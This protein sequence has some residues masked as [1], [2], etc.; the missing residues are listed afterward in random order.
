MFVRTLPS[1]LGVN[2]SGCSPVR[3]LLTI[4]ATLLLTAGGVSATT[5]AAGAQASGA[6]QAWVNGT[7]NPALDTLLPLEEQW[8]ACFYGNSTNNC[9]PQ[10]SAMQTAG[11]EVQGGSNPAPDAR[12]ASDWAN[13]LRNYIEL[14]SIGGGEGLQIVTF[15]AAKSQLAADLGGEGISDSLI[16][17]VVPTTTPPATGSWSLVPTPFV[18][19]V[20]ADG[21]PSSQ[22]AAVSCK[23]ATACIAVGT[24]DT[25]S[26]FQQTLIESWN[27]TTW[28]VVQSPNGGSNA[29]SAPGGDGSL[30][31]VSCVTARWC[32]AVGDFYNVVGDGLGQ[33]NTLALV[34]QGGRWS[35]VPSPDLG[36]GHNELNGVS[37]A[38]VH[39]CVAVGQYLP[40][41]PPCPPSAGTCPNGPG[42]QTLIESWNG[43][44]WSVVPSPSPNP[45]DNNTLSGVSCVSASHC[46]AVGNYVTGTP[47]TQEAILSRLSRGTASG[48]QLAPTQVVRVRICPPCRASKPPRVS[49]SVRLSSRGT[50]ECGPSSSPP[51]SAAPT[52][53]FQGCHV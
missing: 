8:D 47:E 19:P 33:E 3:T 39:A 48:G 28:S 9:Y 24:N 38:S 26:T 10:A 29:T 30:H 20:P 16:G 32:V 50:A 37:C 45:D 22:L 4:V 11:A 42:Y 18:P 14:A 12:I 51:Q 13:F 44:T 49:R 5:A 36:A 7:M 6:L 25:V 35:L 2:G 15:E 41:A 52:W 17:A 43:T 23:S 27:G 31:G 34:L 1:G 46:I 40:P 53:R 21:S